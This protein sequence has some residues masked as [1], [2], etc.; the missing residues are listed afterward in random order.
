MDLFSGSM[1]ETIRKRVI[2]EILESGRTADPDLILKEVA[3]GQTPP[4]RELYNAILEFGGKDFKEANAKLTAI[5]GKDTFNLLNDIAG[6]QVARRVVS[7]EAAA[8][9]GLVSGSIISNILKLQL[10]SAGSIIK[11]RIT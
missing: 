11:Y 6:I 5:L 7:K 2:Q 10:R 4:H 3:T 8:A 9:G 1:Q